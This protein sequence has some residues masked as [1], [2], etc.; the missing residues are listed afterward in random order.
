MATKQQKALERYKARAARAYEDK[1][2]TVR[3]VVSSIEIVGGAG[4]SGYVTAIRPDIAGIPT[5][6]GIGIALLA[7]GMALESADMTAT[8]IGFLAGYARDQGTKLG[9]AGVP[10]WVEDAQDAYQSPYAVGGE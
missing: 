9:A 1:K 7:S 4:V 8:G 6:A 3:A 2:Q 10:G 5:D